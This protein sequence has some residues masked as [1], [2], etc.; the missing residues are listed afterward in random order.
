MLDFDSAKVILKKA[1]NFLFDACKEESCIDNEDKDEIARIDD[2]IQTL[3][4]L[5]FFDDDFI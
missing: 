2:D 4:M 3:E 1:N 5:D